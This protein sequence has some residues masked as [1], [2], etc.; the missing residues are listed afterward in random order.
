MDILQPGGSGAL[1]VVTSKEIVAIAARLSVL[2]PLLVSYL[3]EEAK[4]A[5]AIPC[6]YSKILSSQSH[7]P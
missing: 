7:S 6:K 5:L 1:F 2:P 3:G 4:K